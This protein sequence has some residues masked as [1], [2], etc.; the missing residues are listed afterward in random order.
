MAS[1]PSSSSSSEYQSP[2]WVTINWVYRP[3]FDLPPLPSPNLIFDDLLTK[4]SNF[5][6]VFILSQNLTFVDLLTKCSNFYK[7]FLTPNFGGKVIH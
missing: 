5:Y 3:N 4:C 7:V 6:K 2:G 1:S